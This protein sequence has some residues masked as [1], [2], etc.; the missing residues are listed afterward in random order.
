M[1]KIVGGDGQHSTDE[2]LDLGAEGIEPSRGGA[3]MSVRIATISERQ[4]VID[5]KDAVYDGDLVIA[6]ITRHTTTD[7]TMRHIVES[8]RQVAEEVDGDIAQKGDDQIIVAPTDV[9]G[10]REK[11]N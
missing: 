7:E 11:L 3:G 5:I 8:L 2:Y 4:D 10:A 1:S 9:G 6:D